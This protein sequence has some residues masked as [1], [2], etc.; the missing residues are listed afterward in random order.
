LPLEGLSLVS[1]E[2]EAEAISIELGSTPD[3]HVSHSVIQPAHVWLEQTTE[4]A[5]AA[6][7]I[8]ATDGTQSLLRFR[9]AL[10]S[11]MVDGVVLD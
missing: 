7:E 1:G 5:N 10:P 8:E 2:N 6:L 9:S 4:G 3:D 11:E